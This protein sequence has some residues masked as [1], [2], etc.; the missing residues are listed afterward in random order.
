MV[1]LYDCDKHVW[2]TDTYRFVWVE[3]KISSYV[4][5]LANV[6]LV[7]QQHTLS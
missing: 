4:P 5:N 7:P 2:L 1:G 6:H 3:H